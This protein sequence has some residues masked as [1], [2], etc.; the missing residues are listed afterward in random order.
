[1][2]EHVKEEVND[3]IE[4]EQRTSR[5]LSDEK[6]HWTQEIKDHNVVLEEELKV[7]NEEK[8]ALQ[9]AIDENKSDLE[10]AMEAGRERLEPRA[11]AEK[12]RGGGRIP[13]GAPH[14]KLEV[15]DYADQ[16]DG[17]HDRWIVDDGDRILRAT[18]GG[19]Q[20]VFRDG[21]KV[22]QGEDLNTDMGSWVSQ[23]TGTQKD[24]R[25]QLSYLM[26]IRHDLWLEDQE[27]KR[28]PIEAF[29]RA[30]KAGKVPD[31]KDEAHTYS[32][33]VSI[34]HS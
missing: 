9:V 14:L 2:N 7:A 6:K 30:I 15:H 27:T 21:I 24:G 8:A 33:R 3:R 12:E 11:E 4:S 10:R 34:T 17:Y 29:E 5:S 20:P 18:R 13:L 16:L 31:S 23:P 28:K 26:K 25:P 1:M 22:G 19:Y 32:D